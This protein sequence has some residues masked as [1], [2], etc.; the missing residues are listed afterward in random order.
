MVLP[1]LGVGEVQFSPVSTLHTSEYRKSLAK[2]SPVSGVEKE[3]CDE[4]SGS[5][6]LKCLKSPVHG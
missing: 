6:R 1:S 5:I 4:Q 2:L 3:F